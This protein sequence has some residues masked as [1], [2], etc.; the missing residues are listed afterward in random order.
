[1]VL[2]SALYMPRVFSLLGRSKLRFIVRDIMSNYVVCYNKK[3]TNAYVYLAI[4]T[5]DVIDNKAKINF[6]TLKF[7]KI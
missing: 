7:N 5:L 3:L 2:F 1:M 6:I 4:S